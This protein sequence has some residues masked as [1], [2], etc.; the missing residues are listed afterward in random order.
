GR[1]LRDGCRERPIRRGNRPSRRGRRD[2]LAPAAGCPGGGGSWRVPSPGVRSKPPRY[3]GNG[4]FS[5]IG[6]AAP[7]EE[8]AEG[9]VPVRE[10]LAGD[11]Q[12]LAELSLRQASFGV[13]GGARTSL[14]LHA[15][16]LPESREVVP[17]P[18]ALL[19]P[20]DRGEDASHQP[21]EELA[22]F[23]A[24]VRPDQAHG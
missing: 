6:G 24:G 20:L 8:P 5:G 11:A 2:R 19:Q 12:E 10:A 23:E 15:Q 16:E 13:G 17:R 4:R 21:A 1:D 7:L 9:L 18:G 3:G 22:L 14:S